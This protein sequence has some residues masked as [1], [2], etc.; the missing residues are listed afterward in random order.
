MTRALEG[1]DVVALWD[2]LQAHY[3]T[4]LLDKG[5]AVGMRAVAAL[6]EQLG[7]QDRARFLTEYATTLGTRIYVPFQ[8]GTPVGAWD[9]WQQVVVAV[10]EHQHVVQHVRDGLAYEVGYVTDSSARA[11]HEA[12]AFLCNIELHHWRYGEIPTPRRF[13]EKLASYACTEQDLL[14]AAKYLTLAA[15]TVRLGGTVTEAGAVAL[16]W[17]DEHLPD[18][19]HR[20]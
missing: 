4:R 19:A 18:L 1:A 2:H 14:W 13:A 8:V 20:P 6:L 9:L 10:H 3:G 17:L 12:E 5:D 11:R 16:E 7:V 15:E